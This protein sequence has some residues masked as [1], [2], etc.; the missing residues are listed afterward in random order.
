M[1]ASWDPSRTAAWCPPALAAREGGT[2]FWH[3]LDYEV[4]PRV[5]P[6]GWLIERVHVDRYA[7]HGMA[8]THEAAKRLLEA[9][10]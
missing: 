8:Q 5:R 9:G 6:L 4:F 3:G 2:D 1:P 7:R 10:A